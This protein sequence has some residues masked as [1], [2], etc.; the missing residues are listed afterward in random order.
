VPAGGSSVSRQPAELTACAFLDSR[1]RGRSHTMAGM[2]S[3]TLPAFVAAHR[4]AILGLSRSKVAARTVPRPTRSEIDDGVPLFL[5]LLA[6]ALR[7]GMTAGP[8]A[9]GGADLPGGGFTISQVVHDYADVGQSIIELS[10]EAGVPLTARDLRALNRS[11]D[12]LIATA[13]LQFAREQE[14]VGFSPG[15]PGNERLGFLAHELRNLTSTALIAFDVL[16][17]QNAGVASST[18]AVLHRSIVDMDALIGRSLDEMRLAR[19]VPH[20]EP[21]LVAGLIDD[22]VPAAA[23]RAQAKGVELAVL[24][25]EDGVMVEA[26]REV[27]A[28][29]VQNLLLNAFKFTRPDSTVTLRVGSGADRVL[30]E[31]QDE[32]GGVPEGNVT[33]LFSPFEQRNAD[34]TGLGLGLPFCRWA[35]EANDGRVYG[36]NLPNRGCV[37]TIDLPRLSVPGALG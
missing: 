26:D 32:C 27:L 18:G 21:F 9:G 24:P 6:G 2:A 29:V 22:V 8:K 34:R 30:I 23:L 33:G 12:A 17:S 25:V 36:R 10:H 7:K 19:R 31:V 37:F 11:L 15:E 5:D 1:R 13:V 4:Q 20:R 14:A 16:S 3:G 35:V 28:A